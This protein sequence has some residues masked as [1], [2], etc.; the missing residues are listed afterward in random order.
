[1]KKTSKSVLFLA[2]VLLL[3]L[4]LVSCAKTENKADLWEGATYQEDTE[5]GEGAK[6]AVVE[7]K[8]GEKEIAFTVK[9]DENT[10]G[11]A[12]FEHNLVDGEKGEYGLYVK[13]VNGIVADFD[14]DKS[15]WAFYING[16]YAMSGIDTTEIEKGTTYRLEYTK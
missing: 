16:E 2:L 13:S 8:A 11:A 1:M 6:V 9:T 14:V 3:T 10:V 15:Y 4:S 5:L 12:L 7:V